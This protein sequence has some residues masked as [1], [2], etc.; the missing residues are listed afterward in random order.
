MRL[1][2]QRVKKASVTTVSDGITVGQIGVGLLVLVGFKKGDKETGCD[3]LAGKL[4]KLRVMSDA[5]DKM[6]LSVL[7]TKSEVLVVSQFTLY[8]NTN[9]GNR[10]SFIEAEE[11]DKA[12]VL[13]EYF[14]EKL[15]GLGIKVSTGSFGNY[16]EIDSVLDGPV[17]IILEN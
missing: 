10:P 13:Y 1:L 2:V 7:D 4:S 8:A 14:I 6:N 16:M 17:T 9:G 11:P 5:Q 12:K 15:R 3:L